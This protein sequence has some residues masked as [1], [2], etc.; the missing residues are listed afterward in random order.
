MI[1]D[2]KNKTDIPSVYD[3]ISTF[4][5]FLSLANSSGPESYMKPEI[6]DDVKM[7][8]ESVNELGEV[9]GDENANQNKRSE[10]ESETKPRVDVKQPLQRTIFM[11]GNLLKKIFNLDEKNTSDHQLTRLEKIVEVKIRFKVSGFWEWLI[12]KLYFTEGKSNSKKK[13]GKQSE[14][15]KFLKLMIFQKTCFL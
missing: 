4:I 15:V 11:N 5:E 10:S 12:S 1:K 13:K 3:A 9:N 14:I 8:E 6:E 2:V 7:E